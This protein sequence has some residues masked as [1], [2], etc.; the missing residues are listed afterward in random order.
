MTPPNKTWLS[1]LTDPHKTW[2]SYLTDPQQNLKSFSCQTIG[3]GTYKTTVRQDRTFQFFTNGDSSERLSKQAGQVHCPCHSLIPCTTTITS[4]NNKHTIT[5]NKNTYS[6]QC[7]GPLEV[8]RKPFLWLTIS[9]IF[10]IGYQALV[11]SVFICSHTL[12]VQP[13]RTP[14][15]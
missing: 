10:T 4:I 1:Y 6:V 7:S 2:L 14:P 13:T 3:V 15:F 5:C 8:I 9:D 12:F 11:F